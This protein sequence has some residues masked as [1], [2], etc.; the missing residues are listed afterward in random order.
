[1]KAR[2][3]E[4]AG[5]SHDSPNFRTPFYTN[6]TDTTT[7]EIERERERERENERASFDFFTPEAKLTVCPSTR[8]RQ[9]PLGLPNNTNLKTNHV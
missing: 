8:P 4:D 5:D 1:M 9:R 7:K 3:G 2:E 6:I